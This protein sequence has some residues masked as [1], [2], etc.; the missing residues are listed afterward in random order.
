[1][2]GDPKHWVWE[3]RPEIVCGEPGWTVRCGFAGPG[4]AV[5]A[6]TR[7]GEVEHVRSVAVE[8]LATMFKHEEKHGCRV[9][10]PPVLSGFGL[11]RAMEEILY[12]H[13]YDDGGVGRRACEEG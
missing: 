4:G 6:A 5:V 12:G 10:W 9:V 8:M 2:S 13:L 11:E 7:A 3:E 1:M